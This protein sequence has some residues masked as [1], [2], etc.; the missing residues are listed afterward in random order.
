[1]S[2]IRTFLYLRF[3]SLVIGGIIKW[4]QRDLLWLAGERFELHRRTQ[5]RTQSFRVGANVVWGIRRLILLGALM[6]LAAGGL[7][8][9]P[10]MLGA[11]Q[12]KNDGWRSVL[13]PFGLRLFV[14]PARLAIDHQHGLANEPLPLGMSLV[15]GTGGEIVTITGLAEGS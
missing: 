2:K 14:D 9:L 1:D 13:R 12:S 7:M 4:L 5:H 10:I 15:N 6:I 11:E 3:L 8:M